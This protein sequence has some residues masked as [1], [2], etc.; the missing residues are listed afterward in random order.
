MERGVRDQGLHPGARC[1]FCRGRTE[2]S[3]QLQSRIFDP[4]NFK[5]GGVWQA[6]SGFF[7][8]AGGNY[9][10]G[11]KGRLVGTNAVD[12]SAWGLD[13]RVG[14]HPGVT[15]PRQRVR[16]IK[17]T[18]TVTNT[19]TVTVATPAPP[20]PAPNRPPTVRVHVRP[21]RGRAWTNVEMRGA[22]HGSGRR[23]AD[24]SVDRAGGQ[25]Q[26]DRRGE[27]DVHGTPD[28]RSGHRDRDRNRQREERRVWRQ[29]RCSSSGVR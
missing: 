1:A 11:T 8:H 3:H 6:K 24:V 7:V 16:R 2:A 19:T 4:T 9:S 15:P 20:A 21:E 17:E 23:A 27:H 13:V 5:F 18:T 29:R 10:P 25:L 26:P 12:H 28:G 22:G 14:I